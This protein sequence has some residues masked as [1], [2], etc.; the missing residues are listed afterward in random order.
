[1]KRVIIVHAWDDH[2]KS[3]WY[4]WLKKELEKIGFKVIVPIMPNTSKPKIKE[5]ISYLKKVVGRLDK[6]TYFVGHSIGCQT[7]LRY[8]EQENFRSKIPGILFVA[9]WFK[10]AHLEGKE[11]KK[12]AQ[13][14]LK[15]S[16]NFT[17]IKPKI[18]K[19]TVFLSS[20]EP[21]GYVEENQ[22]I[23]NEKLGAKI[24]IMKNKGHFTSADG[25]DKLFN[26]LNSI[27][28]MMT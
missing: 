22:R 15:T 7:I 26:A 13:P 6:E 2:P 10:L 25:V 14:W 28:E 20:N 24:V 27:K 23:F 21:Y 1:M 8:L 11:V 16:I 5:W 3:N 18:S 4:P 17:K 9:G 12:I 19:L